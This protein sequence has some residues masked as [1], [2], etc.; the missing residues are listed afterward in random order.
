MLVGSVSWCGFVPVISCK[1]THFSDA[2]VLQLVCVLTFVHIVCL[3]WFIT[4]L[5]LMINLICT[6]TFPL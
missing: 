4:A 2:D 6:L 5:K 3:W 1:V